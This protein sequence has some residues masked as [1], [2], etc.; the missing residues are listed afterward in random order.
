MCMSSNPSRTWSIRRLFVFVLTLVSTVGCDQGAKLTPNPK[1]E[2][3]KVT[4]FPEGTVDQRLHG[5][6]AF[7]P[8]GQT[9]AVANTDGVVKLCNLT[10]GK[11][12]DL[13]SPYPYKEGP[14][15]YNNVVYSKRG[16]YLAVAY[17]QRAIVVRDM[18]GMK[19]KVRIDLENA[20]VHS[21]VFTDDD[22]TLL[23]LLM[24]FANDAPPEPD[25][26]RPLKY[27]AVRWNVA[28]GKRLGA[29][30]F[31]RYCQFQVLSPDGRYAVV[32]FRSKP[33]SNPFFDGYHVV[34]LA[35]GA[36]LFQVGGFGFDPDWVVLAGS[37]AF[38]ADGSTFVTCNQKGLLIREVPSGR[39]LRY[40]G[41]T[42]FVTSNAS[43]SSDGK[44]LAVNVGCVSLINIETGNSLGD[45]DCG[46]GCASVLISPDGRLMATQTETI[47]A[48]DK[49]VMP[50]LKLWKVHT[51]WRAGARVD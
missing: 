6:M 28:S 4:A 26:G 12:V 44:L 11:V 47:D 8:D 9:L 16:Q 51:S 18:P 20:G 46:G 14:D 50:L 29:V 40:F 42:S 37:W 5:D 19:E 3:V 32:E 49:P 7:S 30:D 25:G 15:W 48:K 35:T 13:P 31:G 45:V 38:S 21:M 24:T 34:D 23:G 27:L 36:K 39:K 41:K 43:L 17:E 33:G 10:R 1:G 22:Q 2:D